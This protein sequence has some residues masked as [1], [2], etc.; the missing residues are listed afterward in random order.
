M[1]PAGGLIFAHASIGLLPDHESVMFLMPA[2]PALLVA[3]IVVGA[4]LER[5]GVFGAAGRTVSLTTPLAV[6]AAGLSLAAAG[7]HFAVL[8]DHLEVDLSEGVFFFALG[9]FQLI[10]A[11]VYLLRAHRRIAAAAVVVNAA[12]VL[13]WLASRT[14]GLP[15]GPQP[16]VPEQIG[17]ADLLATT[18]EVGLIGLLL[19]SILTGRFTRLEQS[20]LP[21]QKAFVLAAFMIVTVSLLTGLALVPGAF[22]VLNF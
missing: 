15:I 12:T 22:A 14:V 20:Q 4:T 10:W 17:L 19:P 3:T 5:R 21:A 16:W 9:W 18:F 6:I 8:Q 11:Q 13:I 1:D 2:L 7:I